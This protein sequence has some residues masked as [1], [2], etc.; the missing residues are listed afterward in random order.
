MTQHNG[1]R[2]ISIECCYAECYCTEHRDDLNVMMS[3]VML[4][5][6]MLN[7]VMLNVVVLDVV[8]L[9][10]VMLNVAA[11]CLIPWS[12]TD[13]I[14]YSTQGSGPTH[15]YQTSLKTLAQEET[16]QLTLAQCQ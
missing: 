10:V 5:V 3:T 14:M 2:H 4:S 11:P 6:V 1:T 8:M 16:L 12:G 9:S 13:S 15:K 7:V